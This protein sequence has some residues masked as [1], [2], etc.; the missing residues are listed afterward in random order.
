MSRIFSLNLAK[1]T[2]KLKK[3]IAEHPDYPIV[4]LVGDEA[5]TGDCNWMYCTSISFE[6][7]EILDYELPYDNEFVCCDRDEFNERFEDWLWGELGGCDNPPKITEEEFQK[8]LS[9]EKEKYEPY[10]KKVIAILSDN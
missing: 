2:D 4:V 9:E 8:T 10:W 7:G 5:N 1:N 6:V 3:L